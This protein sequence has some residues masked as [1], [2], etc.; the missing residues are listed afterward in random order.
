MA[1][2]HQG[3]TGD[4]Q[5]EPDEVAIPDRSSPAAPAE[6]PEMSERWAAVVQAYQALRER[7]PLPGSAAAITPQD[8]AGHAPPP[9]G[10]PAGPSLPRRVREAG[11][12]RPHR[13][14]GIAALWRVGAP[15]A[16]ASSANGLRVPPAEAAPAKRDEVTPGRASPGANGSRVP[17][18]GEASAADRERRDPADP[19]LRPAERTA[20]VRAPHN[21]L[22][23]GIATRGWVKTLTVMVGVVIVVSAGVGALLT[24]RADDDSATVTTTPAPAEP[25]IDVPVVLRSGRVDRT[26]VVHVPASYDGS[27]AVPLVLVLHGSGGSAEIADRISGMS[28]KSD[29]AGFLA[30]YPE[31]TGRSATFNAGQCCGIAGARMID[32]VSFMRDVVADVSADYLVDARRIYAAG[33]SNGA[34]MVHRLGCEMSDVLAAIAPVAGA[35]EVDCAPAGPVSAIVFHG[36]ADLIVPYAGGPAETVPGGMDSEYDPVSTAVDVWAT[37]GGCTGAT[38]EQVSASVVRQ[39][40][41]GCMAGYGVELYTVDGGGHAWPGGEPGWAGGDVPTTEVVATDLIWDFFAAH[42]KP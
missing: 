38:D 28:A 3:R 26:Y 20:A 9:A 17:A 36:K 21:G 37:T 31:G 7:R 39:V 41:T 10:A 27:Q 23:T 42:P 4:S 29:A 12:V 1:G 33:M 13:R 5:H 8:G 22:H 11:A 30:V 24:A 35:L 18:T 34:M 25:G 2:P 14:E 6:S 40:R 19:S 16:E 32:D 15:G